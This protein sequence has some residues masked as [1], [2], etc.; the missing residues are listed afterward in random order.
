VLLADHTASAHLP[1]SRSLIF[2]IDGLVASLGL[3]PLDSLHSHQKEAARTLGNCLLVA[4]TGSGK[5]EAAILWAGCQKTADQSTGRV[6]YIL[7]YQA[8]INA[9]HSRLS[10]IF[11]NA[12]ALQHSRSVQALYRRLL[13]EKEY[14]SAKAAVEARREQAL[15][16]L[17]HH[18]VRV[19]T[20]YQLLRGAFRLKGYEAL[21]TDATDGLFIFDEVHAYDTRRLGMILGM[22]DYLG[23]RLGGRF[24]V[25]SATFPKVLRD[26]LSDALLEVKTV[27]SSAA[28]YRAFSRH[29]LRLVDG[30]IGDPNVLKKIAE[31][32]YDGDSVLV[33]C[34]TVRMATEVRRLL[35]DHLRESNID[36]ELLHSRFNSRD[37][38]SKE[39]KLLGRLGTRNR[40]AKAV[41][42]IL[43]A[44]QVVEVSLDLD[45]DTVF[46]EPAPLESLVQ[47]FGRVNRGRRR[48]SCDVY[49]VK[50]PQHGQGVYDDDY[51]IGALRT[52]EPHNGAALDESRIGTWLNEIYAGA[53]GER[54]SREVR[55]WRDEFH[56]ACLTE[57]RAFQS[58]PE[59]AEAFD[60]MFD[61][62]EVLPVSLFAE[63][64]P[65]LE[66]NPLSAS[67]LLVPISS[68]QLRHLRKIGKVRSEEDT[69]IVDVPYSREGGLNL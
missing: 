36:A 21:F 64:G 9:M 10:S 31:R 29:T 55:Q 45:F 35:N 46:T 34:N 8:S 4:P 30:S 28:M 7:P 5:T 63:Y 57:L 52:I 54:W 12:V 43:V 19:L 2:D 50:A 61:G 25:M 33:V 6:F 58:S 68:A 40:D 66:E 23:R 26:L 67:E 13:E 11:P 20:P 48:A 27:E 37:R 3:G 53:V 59:L 51:V 32:A 65:L 17:H 47:R 14:T 49:V 62:T 44:T 22:I 24:L 56:G 42:A 18:P 15:A 1:Q 60:R 38:F 16:R 69:I 39:R 41:P